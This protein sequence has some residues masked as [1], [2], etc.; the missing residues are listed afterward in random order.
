MKT[1][2]YESWVIEYD[3]VLTR[4]IYNDLTSGTENC[5]CQLCINFSHARGSVYPDSFKKMLDQLGIDAEKET[6]ICQF[7][8]L[9]PGWHL[10]AGWFHFVGTIKKAPSDELTYKQV[11][12]ESDFSWYFRSKKDLLPKAFGQNPVVQLNWIG[13]VPWVIDAEEP[14]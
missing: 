2:L 5:G 10:Y 4:S 12:D 3:D 1:L 8:R 11:P 7:N 6:E 13:K 9:S 14:T